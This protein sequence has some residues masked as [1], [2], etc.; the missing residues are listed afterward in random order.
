[1][2]L[3][4]GETLVDPLGPNVPTPGLIVTLVASV[5]DQESMDNPPLVIDDGLAVRFT[6][7]FVGG[8]GGGGGGGD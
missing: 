5:E 2:V 6:V 8:G 3:T 1:M 7:G 4:P